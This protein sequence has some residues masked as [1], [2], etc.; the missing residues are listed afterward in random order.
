MKELIRK[1]LSLPLLILG[2]IVTS[3]G[4][5]E[6]KPGVYYAL[7]S[8][9]DHGY[10]I[11]QE[12]AG[13]DVTGKYYIDDGRLVSYP[14][15]VVAKGH[16][17]G[18][19]L[20]FPDGEKVVYTSA[21]YEA[22]QYVE[23]AEFHPYTT[24]SYR[25]E[26]ERDVV[27]G[28]AKGY[29]TSYI[30]EWTESFPVTYGRK[31]FD[32]DLRDQSLKMDIYK[33]VDGGKTPR[34]VI[35]LIH[36]G[37]F[38]N[39]DKSDPD[40]VAWGQHF[41]S[42]GYVAASI[43]YRLGFDLLKKGE[44]NRAGYRG[45]QDA[46]AAMR[47]LLNRSDLNIDRNL[48]YVAGVSAGAITAL[49]VAFMKEENRP[50]DTYEGP[51]GDE[52]TLDSVNPAVKADFSVRAVGN[53]WG[54]VQDLSMLS[55]SRT[56]VISFHSA[57]DPTVPYGEGSPFSGMLRFA[58]GWLFDTMWGSSEIHKKAQGLGLRSEFH[59]YYLKDTHT[60]DRDPS[61]GHLNSTFYDI[62]KMLTNFFEDVMISRPAVITFSGKRRYSINASEVKN[63]SWK[64]EGGLILNSFKQS[65]RIMLFGDAPRQS[66]TVSGEYKNGRTF[67]DTYVIK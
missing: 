66:L 51:L 30:S 60:L 58:S 1:R 11:F 41:A 12:S 49:N 3:C 56:S 10:A 45:L 40:F 34:P 61:D 19:K 32:M 8:S 21:L 52:G 18:V 7:S 29:W 15:E 4:V 67:K 27:Y 63:S 59:P 35:L 33:P 31:L 9:R 57:Y 20:K 28:K 43:N 6:I 25:V 37:A 53:M 54:A 64:V 44:V 2:F 26:V 24:P 47:T 48:I 42:L 5:T 17:K 14:V 65:A 22:P 36:G 50:K 46:R 55:N 38:F 23:K 39:G 16:R 62:Q 13:K